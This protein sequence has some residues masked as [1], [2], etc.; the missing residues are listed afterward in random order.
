M[1]AGN[2]KLYKQ[3][4]ILLFWSWD[5]NYKSLLCNYSY[6]GIKQ[7]SLCKSAF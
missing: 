7:R 5:S 2:N 3:E 4:N 1:F 6:R